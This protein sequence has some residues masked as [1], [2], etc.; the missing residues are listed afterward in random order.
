MRNYPLKF[1]TLFSIHPVDYQFLKDN[2]IL[3]I[4]YEV[5]NFLASFFC[6]VCK[7]HQ[8]YHMIL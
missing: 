1:F 8:K 3:V 4:N 7:I 6:N 2:A 5:P